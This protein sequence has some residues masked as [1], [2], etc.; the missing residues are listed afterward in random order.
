MFPERQVIPRILLLLQHSTRNFLPNAL[1]IRYYALN[2]FC[3][4]DMCVY[5]YVFSI[6]NEISLEIYIL[7]FNL[8]RITYLYSIFGEL[9]KNTICI[10]NWKKKYID[11]Y[12]LSL[13][14]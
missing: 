13:N 11:I 14:E 8:P 6:Y 10:L 5:I 1:S 12:L 2:Q 4:L 7:K 9:D 3:Q